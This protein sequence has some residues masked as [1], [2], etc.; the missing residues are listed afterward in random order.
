MLSSVTRQSTPQTENEN[1]CSI[2][3]STPQPQLQEQ[4]SNTQ[5]SPCYTLKSKRLG[6]CT[7]AYPISIS[8]RS[9]LKQTTLSST[10]ISNCAMDIN[11][12]YNSNCVIV[13]NADFTKFV[14]HND[15]ASCFLNTSR[16]VQVIVDRSSSDCSSEFPAI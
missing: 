11:A 15:E 10:P 7:I 4:H 1:E 6:N 3:E 13:I 2:L 16:E 8:L 14:G 12:G 9:I 5:H